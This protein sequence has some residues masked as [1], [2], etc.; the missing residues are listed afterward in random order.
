[1][2]SIEALKQEITPKLILKSLLSAAVIIIIAGLVAVL[3]EAFVFKSTYVESISMEPTINPGDRVFVDRLT[4]YFRKPRPGDIVVFRYPPRGSGSRNTTN[5]LYW[6]FEQV[7]EILRLTHRT[8]FSPYVKRVVATEGQTIRIVA[9]VVFVN[10]KRVSE[11][12]VAKDFSNFGPL[13]VGKGMV[14]CLGDDRGNSSDS[15]IIGRVWL[16]W[17][18][19]SRFGRLPG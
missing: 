11:P 18:P 1:M 19:F 12:Y 9:G 8:G 10:G 15:S 6:P 4:Y 3:M 2:K 14:F 13:R 7:G 16:R 5:L 17:W